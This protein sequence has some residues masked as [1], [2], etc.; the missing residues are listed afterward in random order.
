MNTESYIG[1]TAHFV[2]E[3]FDLKTILLECKLMAGHHTSKNL[4][5]E[6]SNIAKI[7]LIVSDNASNVKLNFKNFGCFAHTLNLIVKIYQRFYHY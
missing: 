2:N 4:A 5:N 7:L 3:D 6:I 1:L